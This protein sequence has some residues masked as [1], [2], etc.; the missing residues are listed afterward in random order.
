MGTLYLV[1]TPIGNL[2]DITLRALRVLREAALIAAEDTRTTRNLLTHFQIS[3]PCTSYHEHNKLG[4]L[5]AIFAALEAGDVALVSDAGTPGISDPGYELVQAAIQRGF[6]VTPLP[7][8]NAAITALVASGLPTETFIFLGFAPKKDKARRTLLTALA[9]VERTLIFYESPHRLTDLLAVIAELLP[10]R[11]V[12]VAR[13]LSK[14]YEE[15]VRG[16]AA[17]AL[18]H[19]KASPPRGEIVVLIE[20][21]TPS[22][23]EPWDEA[24]VRERLRALLGEGLSVRDAATQVAGESAWDRGEVYALAVQER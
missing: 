21:H 15:F 6:S 22:A 17:S 1:P 16:T 11:K 10:E 13:E 7:G 4:K 20:G 23:P 9:H 2:E 12:C 19:Y 24:D 18:A 8:A 5:D 14:I 3:T